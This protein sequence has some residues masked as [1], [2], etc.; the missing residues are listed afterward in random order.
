MDR[1]AYKELMLFKQ[2]YPGSVTWFRLKKHCEII[3]KHLNPNETIQF[4]I[5]GQ[6]D[7]DN[8]SFFNTGVLALTSER[9]IIAQNRL[10]VGYKFSSITPDLF[11]D[12]QVSTGLIWGNLTIDTLKEKVHM[13]NLA[14]SSLPEIETQITMFMQEAKKQYARRDED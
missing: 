10:L 13:S 7:N 3:D 5:A 8:L 4:C 1:D 2:K 6:L 9:I 14:K 12:L 11:N